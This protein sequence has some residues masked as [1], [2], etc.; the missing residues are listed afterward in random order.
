[1][2]NALKDAE[3]WINEGWLTLRPLVSRC[4][5]GCGRQISDNRVLCM[6]CLTLK[7]IEF[8]A[9]LDKQMADKAKHLLDDWQL[10][11]IEEKVEAFGQREA[12]AAMV[13]AHDVAV[14]E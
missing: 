2:N 11:E 12:A 13:K 10:A 7:R 6:K 1:M 4:A 14:A 9:K 8:E 5:N 3:S